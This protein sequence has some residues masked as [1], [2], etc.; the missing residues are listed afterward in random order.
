M[1]SQLLVVFNLSL[2]PLA[3]HTLSTLGLNDRLRNSIKPPSYDVNP[4]LV[5]FT[6]LPPCIEGQ[7]VFQNK[8]KEKE[9]VKRKEK[10]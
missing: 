6:P 10:N 2:P 5:S 3:S 9:K 8:R 7:C 4:Y 1:T